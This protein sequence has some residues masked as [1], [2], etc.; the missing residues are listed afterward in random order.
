[1][2]ALKNLKAVMK[3]GWIAMDKD[4]EWFWHKEAPWIIHQR[5]ISLNGCA[6]ISMVFEI[7]DSCV[8]WEKSCQKVGE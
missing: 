5:W 7:E 3:K 1:M 2:V 8:D 6:R 4:G